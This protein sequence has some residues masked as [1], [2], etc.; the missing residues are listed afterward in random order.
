V[1][2]SNRDARI[3]VGKVMPDGTV[4]PVF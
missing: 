3:V 1:K 2:G 4:K